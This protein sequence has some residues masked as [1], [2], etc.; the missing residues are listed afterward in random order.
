MHEEWK[1]LGIIHM[2]QNISRITCS[3]SGTTCLICV[4]DTIRPADLYGVYKASRCK[5]HTDRTRILYCT[6]MNLNNHVNKLIWWYA[7]F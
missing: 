1:F 7:L 2:K 6:S 4:I 3:Q 5:S